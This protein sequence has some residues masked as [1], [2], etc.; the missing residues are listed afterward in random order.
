VAPFD[1]NPLAAPTFDDEA[2]DDLA[3]ARFFSG[4]R[5][6]AHRR[7]DAADLGLQA[8]ADRYADATPRTWALLRLS[9]DMV[10]LLDERVDQ[11]QRRA[12]HRTPPD[13][14]QPPD[15]S[16]FAHI[17]WA[18]VREN[19]RAEASAH[20]RRRLLNQL[21]EVALLE[22][23]APGSDG[24]LRDLLVQRVAE[25]RSFLEIIRHRLDTGHVPFHE[26]PGVV[27]SALA[28]PDLGSVRAAALDWLADCP[29]PSLVLRWSGVHVALELPADA[30]FSPSCA[31]FLH[32]LT[33]PLPAE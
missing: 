13:P 27:E 22:P 16:L 3:L 1:T 11:G 10:Q 9:V 30:V 4:V 20:A 23:D 15:P 8:L 29:E 6:E 26:L 21:P 17:E 7:L 19:Q 32:A 18:R 14:L 33:Q 31:A 25:L 24:E 12:R 28:D 5:V 2:C